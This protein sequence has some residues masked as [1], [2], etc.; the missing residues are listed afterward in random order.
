MTDKRVPI[1]FINYRHDDT[2]EFANRLNET[3]TRRFGARHIFLDSQAIEGGA[4]FSESIRDAL[5]SS[6]VLVAIVGKNWLARTS[7]GKQRLDEAH[8][9]VR[10]EIAS[11]LENDIKVVP[12]LVEETSIPRVQNLP[13]GLHKLATYHWIRIRERTWQADTK[14]LSKTIA[15]EF[16]K[17]YPYSPVFSAIA[18]MIS[19]LVVGAI[20]SY[21]RKVGLERIA[22]HGLY[23]LVAAVLL[24]MFVRA[25]IMRFAKLSNGSPYAK[26]IGGTLGAVLGGVLTAILGGFAFAWLPGGAGN[27]FQITLSVAICGMLITGG[28]FLPALKESWTNASSL[29]LTPVGNHHYSWDYLGLAVSRKSMGRTRNQQPR[30]EQ[31]AVL[32][33]S[34]NP[35]PNQRTLVGD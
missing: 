11:A 14:K 16:Q 8:D 21:Q 4:D 9:Y 3:L 2:S 15:K 19:G 13:E 17:Y 24:S 27:P 7:D 35:W 34:A 1:I 25:G 26:I 18:G 20:Y 32:A 6:I 23:G 12:V 29:G 5:S 30:A 22:L 33:R 10:L 31:F 28:F